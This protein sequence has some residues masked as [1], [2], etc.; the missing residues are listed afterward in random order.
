V[1]SRGPSVA[2]SRPR[3]AARGDG[4]EGHPRRG[5]GRS[6]DAPGR[7]EARWSQRTGVNPPPECRASLAPGTARSSS[8]PV[9][10]LRRDDHPGSRH[11]SRIVAA[12]RPRSATGSPRNP[13]VVRLGA[14]HDRDCVRIPESEV[15]RIRRG[16]RATRAGRPGEAARGDECAI[17]IVG[18]SAPRPGGRERAM[19]TTPARAG[20]IALAAPGARAS[21]GGPPEDEGARSDSCKAQGGP[22]TRSGFGSRT[23]PTP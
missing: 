22:G 4:R 5:V 7:P 14:T 21:P 2:V 13:T 19:R 1:A 3:R 12:A 10:P 18:E 17:G 20:M 6:A 8:P 23:S 11:G 16:V 9:P 15:E